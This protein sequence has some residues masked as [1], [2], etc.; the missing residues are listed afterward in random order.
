MRIIKKLPRTL[1][2][3]LSLIMVCAI[4]LLLSAALIVMLQY[5]RNVIRTDAMKDAEHTLEGTSTHIDNIMLSVEQ[6]AGNFYYDLMRHVN[7]PDRME[8]YCRELVM[9]N[10]YIVGCVIAFEPYYY[11]AREKAMTYVRRAVRGGN[12]LDDDFDLLE[13]LHSVPGKHYTEL[14]WYTETMEV[15]RACWIEPVKGGKPDDALISFCLPIYDFKGRKFEARE[16][17]KPVG[18]VRV[19]VPLVRLTDFIHRAKPSANGY[20][21][22]LGK[23]GE[24]I[25]H[26]DT[27]KLM[28]ETVF[29]QTE[30]GAD[31]SVL[32]AAQAMVAGESGFMPFKM[33][34]EEWYV[35]YKPFERSKAPGRIMTSLGWSVGVAYPDSDIFSQYKKL[36]FYLYVIA[37]IGLFT[38]FVLC[39]LFTHRQLMPLTLLTVSAQ[40]IAEGHYNET[41]PDTKR[42]DEIGQLQSHFQKMQEALAA[43][44]GQ[45]EQLSAQ[46]QQRGEELQEAHRQ[47]QEADRM[48]TSFLHYMTNQMVAPS[49]AIDKSVTTICNHFEDINANEFAR[50]ADIISSSSEEIVRVLE[51]MLKTAESKQGKEG[52]DD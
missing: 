32:K 43:H 34:G 5:S 26:P 22:L 31:P 16:D 33:N 49:D 19:I 13:T 18:V 27:T 23:E 40:R 8:D 6:T 12:W 30:H 48:K 39:R 50:Q 20:S 42:G 3:R 10:R 29:T 52:A 24:Y 36:L 45:E 14:P 28:Y 11:S 41:V 46:L 1:S 37:F 47:A 15:N 21:V 35:I 7:E 51:H 17:L 38:F 4:A 2:L 44:I 25:V 9:S